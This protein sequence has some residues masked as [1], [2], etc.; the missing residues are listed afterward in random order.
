MWI[1]C[2]EKVKVL[3]RW[4]GWLGGKVISCFAYQN[5]SALCFQLWNLERGPLRNLAYHFRSL[6]CGAQKYNDMDMD[7][8]CWR[9]EAIPLMFFF[10]VNPWIHKHTA[11]IINIIFSTHIKIHVERWETSYF[12]H[13]LS[14][15]SKAESDCET[16]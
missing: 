6:P 11:M 1:Q 8:C 5:V 15:R 7:K 10:R 16:K 3:C 12:I 14:Q 13:N 2:V 4:L 9:S